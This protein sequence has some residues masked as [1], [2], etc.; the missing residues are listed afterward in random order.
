M[1]WFQ[2]LESDGKVLGQLFI[3]LA[4]HHRLAGVQVLH[5]S[6]VK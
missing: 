4:K 1:R 6:H 5:A 2:W 3:Q